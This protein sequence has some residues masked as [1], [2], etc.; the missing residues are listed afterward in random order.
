MSDVVGGISVP[1][2]NPRLCETEKCYI[3][4]KRKM[5]NHAFFCFRCSY[6]ARKSDPKR[7]EF[8]ADCQKHEHA[9]LITMERLNAVKEQKKIERA[10]MISVASLSVEASGITQEVDQLQVH[11]MPTVVLNTR[12]ATAKNKR[13]RDEIVAAVAQ[14]DATSA[15]MDATSAPTDA[16]SAQTDATSAQT[17]ATSAPTDTA[18]GIIVRA[19]RRIV[20][21]IRR[22]F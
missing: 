5:M 19:V 8:E 11:L 2:V 15:Q 17:D 13:A 7:E 6:K 21:P 3:R 4:Q 10:D 12:L 22:Y 20:R 14:T 16:T 1:K 18:D 9:T